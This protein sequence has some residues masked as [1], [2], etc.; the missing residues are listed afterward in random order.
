MKLR[1]DAETGQPLTPVIQQAEAQGY[2]PAHANLA[3]ARFEARQVYIA[4]QEVHHDDL[5][6]KWVRHYSELDPGWNGAQLSRVQEQ[7]LAT[8]IQNGLTAHETLCTYKQQGITSGVDYDTAKQAADYG[9]TARKALFETN[10]PFAHYFARESVGIKHPNSQRKLGATAAASSRKMSGRAAGTYRALH[11][12]KSPYADLEHREQSALEGMWEATANYKPNGGDSKA[13]FVDYAAW[14][15]QSRIERD[16]HWEEHNTIRL[17]ENVHQTIQS[18]LRDYLPSD[19]DGERSRGAEALIG[20]TDYVTF[21]EELGVRCEGGIADLNDPWGEHDVAESFAE[22]WAD[23]RETADLSERVSARLASMAVNSMLDSLSEREAKVIR[24]RFGIVLD[25]P[26]E[27]EE[28]SPKTLDEVGDVLGVTR[29]RVRQ[30]EIKAMAKLRHPSRSESLRDYL[31]DAPMSV[32]NK[33]GDVT[34]LP[35]DVAAHNGIRYEEHYH[36]PIGTDEEQHP[37]KRPGRK[38][39]EPWRMLLNESW[40]TAIRSNIEEQIDVELLAGVIELLDEAQTWHF[41]LRTDEREKRPYSLGLM[42]RINTYCG[43]KRLSTQEL[44]AVWDVFMHSGYKRLKE[45]LGSNMSYDRVGRFFSSL[46]ATHMES[47]WKDGQ[48]LTLRIPPEADRQ[49]SYLASGL[50]MGRVKIIGNVGHHVAAGNAGLSEVTIKGNT[51]SYA[52]A[53]MKGY[54]SLRITGD[55]GFHLGDLSR[56]DAFIEAFRAESMGAIKGLDT[57]IRVGWRDFI[58]PQ[59]TQ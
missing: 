14:H 29:E 37:S 46:I 4:S 26:G 8:Y 35:F 52:G 24:M 25:G 59:A 47:H 53:Y 34:L 50:R 22:M 9:D 38:G 6:S 32:P 51:G 3:Q 39:L 17:P 54:A 48:E 15:I 20:M 7:S 40:G 36:R 58:G 19:T 55:T 49:I 13:R 28:D 57:K 10:M 1:V 43:E 56:D 30:I 16:M 18:Y 11:S 42:S 5:R 27:F 2:S 33:S 44:E 45:S 23:D 31:D 12:L 21:P 41:D